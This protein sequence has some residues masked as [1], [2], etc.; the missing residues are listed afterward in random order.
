[1]KK[2]IQAVV[3]GVVKKENKY[4]LTKRKD[5]KGSKY[6]DKWQLPGGGLEFYET[7]EQGVRREIR[8]ET[9]LILN[10]KIILIPCVYEDIRRSWHGVLISFLCTP[11]DPHQQVKIDHEASDYGWFTVEEI[12]NLDKFGDTMAIVTAAEKLSTSE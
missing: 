12:E 3:I 8:E 6:H 4:L 11:A 9:S 5:K 2:T 10:E 7:V 1:M